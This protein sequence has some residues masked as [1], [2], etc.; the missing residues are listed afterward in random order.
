MCLVDS[1]NNSFGMCLD[2][3]LIIALIIVVCALLVQGSRKTGEVE[4]LAVSHSGVK[5]LRK[6]HGHHLTILSSYK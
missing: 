2:D 3:V 1:L 6:E 4:M 5:L